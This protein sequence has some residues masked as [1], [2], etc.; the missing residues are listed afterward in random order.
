VTVPFRAWLAGRELPTVTVPVPTDA[1]AYAAAERE[2][3]AAAQALLTAHQSGETDLEAERAAYGRAAAALDEVPTRRLTLRALPADVWD[4]LVEAHPPTDEERAKGASWAVKTFRPVLIAASVQ[5]EAGEE[6]LSAEEW[7]DAVSAGHLTL[8]EL[9][10]LFD[11]AI[12]LNGRAP[13]VSTG[14]G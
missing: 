10:R 4:E 12:S 3:A 8:G 2:L 7:T 13:R 6:P 14:K 11:E 5:A 1:S 9:N